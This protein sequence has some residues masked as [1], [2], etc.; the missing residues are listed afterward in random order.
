[1]WKRIRPM[2]PHAAILLGNVMVVLFALEQINPSMN[3]IDNGLTKGLL[4][5]MALVSA[6]IWLDCADYER[7]LARARARKAGRKA[8]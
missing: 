1:M 8:A 5:V 2:L 3:F 7:R 4:A 6:L